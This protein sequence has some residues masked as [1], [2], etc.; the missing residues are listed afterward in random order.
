MKSHLE[1][2][3]RRADADPFFLGCLLQHYALSEG[4][5][6]Q[7]L[8]TKL[9]CSSESM[10]LVRLCRAPCGES[11]QFQKAIEE[12]SAKFNIDPDLLATA[13]RLGQAIVQL[14]RPC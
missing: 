1:S 14:A 11:Q 13:V 4:L 2:L 9:G 7:Q 8:M 12:I 3:A 5:T 10:I 6:E